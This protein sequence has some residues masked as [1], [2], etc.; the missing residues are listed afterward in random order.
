MMENVMILRS[1][2]IESQPLPG[3]SSQ[4]G[5]SIKRIVYPQNVPTKSLFMGITEVNPGYSPH[6]WHNHVR[7]VA[8]GYEIVYPQGFEEIYYIIS[9][10]GTIQW[11]TPEGTLKEE[12]V[13]SGDT[14]FFPSGVR[15]HQLLNSGSEKMVVAYI[16]S[17]IPKIKNE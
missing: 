13:T 14:L 7:N 9:G 2:E 5:G 1:S 6:R 11:K 17:P 10:R 15:E 12:E 4:E 3:S 16:G 8:E